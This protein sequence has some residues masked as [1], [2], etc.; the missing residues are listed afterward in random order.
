MFSLIVPT[1]NEKESIAAF[2]QRAQDVLKAHPYEIIVVDDN[3]PDGTAD[4][5][6]NL[7]SSESH[8]RLIVRKNERGL[9]SAVMEGFSQAKGGVLIAMDADG[10]H[11]AGLIP[12]MISEIESK[13]ADCVIGSR[14]LRGGG[15]QYPALRRWISKFSAWLS[16]AI[17]GLNVTDP[18]SGFFCVTAEA[19]RRAAPELK[20]RGFKILL[21]LLMRNRSL[22]VV[23]L[24]YVFVDRTQGKSKLSLSVILA[25]FMQS[26]E[27]LAHRLLIRQN[28]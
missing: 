8:I 13:Q 22:R 28:R 3:S 11:D 17:L 10:S 21:E 4:I 19:Y 27:I 24:P 16:R 26:V 7:Q 5:V 15:N 1:Y 6:K 18:L 25:F 20:P 23:E 2:I 9:S 14:Y 12:K